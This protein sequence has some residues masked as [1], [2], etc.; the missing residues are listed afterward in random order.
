[1]PSA[2]SIDDDNFILTST[3]GKVKRYMTSE[4]E[5]MIE[6]VEELEEE[7]RNSLAP[8]L[9]SMFGH[10]YKFRSIFTNA[11]SCVAELDCLNSLACLSAK[12]KMCK[13]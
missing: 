2:S 5:R 6:E 11:V 9:R 10:F 7:L 12:K 13:P 3:T 4:L 8:F 1:M